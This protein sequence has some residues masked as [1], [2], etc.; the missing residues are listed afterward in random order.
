MA[1][2]TVVFLP[3]LIVLAFGLAGYLLLDRRRLR[4]VIPLTALLVACGAAAAVVA[5]RIVVGL[6]VLV[7]GLLIG[8]MRLGDVALRPRAQGTGMAAG[9][10]LASWFD[11]LLFAL[12]PHVAEA[13]A[14]LALQ[15][16]L[17]GVRSYC[18]G[19]GTLIAALLFLYALYES[20]VVDVDLS[21]PSD[22][23]R[24]RSYLVGRGLTTL[25]VNVALGIIQGETGATLARRLSYSRGAIN[26]ARREAY[27]LLGVHTRQEL[28]ELVER[29]TR[30]ALRAT[31]LAP[32]RASPARAQQ[33]HDSASS[34][35][36]A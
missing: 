27:R 14:D 35:K 21:R 2:S 13:H 8:C 15:V 4:F 28:I 32:G 10:F 19:A 11:M 34:R 22:S 31:S 12:V 6:M 1:G 23:E 20:L 5:Q 36:D 25:Q 33:G 17:T 18:L 29:D 3:C 7:A 26:G 24:L 16:W 9:I 30:I